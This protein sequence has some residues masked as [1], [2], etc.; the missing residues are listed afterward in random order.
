MTATKIIDVAV[1]VLLREDGA[2]LLAQR[3]AGKVYE[4]YW[5]FPGGKVEA[6]E[7]PLQALGR[8]LHEEL[9]IADIAAHPW[10]TRV[11]AYPHATVRLHF[12]RVFAWHGEPHGREDQQLSWQLLPQLSVAPLLPANAP[13]LRALELPCLYA[14]SNAAELGC[15]EFMRRLECALQD[16][17]RLLQVREK[18][19]PGEALARFAAQVGQLAHRYGAKV[20][21]N[22]DAELARCSG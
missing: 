8:E 17:L 3:P 4:G 5:E 14:I 1:A 6:R 20:L 19:L 7:T 2:F 16:G 13:I 11:F 15:E 18:N 10:L 22:G 9:G 12:F 21:V